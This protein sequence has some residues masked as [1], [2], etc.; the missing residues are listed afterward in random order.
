MRFSRLLILLLCCSLSACDS[1]QSA[2]FKYLAEPSPPEAPEGVEVVRDVGFTETPSGVLK[3]DIY[4][5]VNR[6]EQPLP[7]VV[8]LFG[9]GWEMGNRHQVGGLLGIYHFAQQG[10]AVISIDYRLSSVAIFPAQINDSKAAIRWV[11]LFAEEFQLDAERIGVLGP[12]AGGHLAAL[13]GTSGD[14]AELEGAL[15][16]LASEQLSSRVHAVVDF[17]GP[18]DML[19]A[20][21]HRYSDM[22]DWDAAD[23]PA[24]KLLGG[25]LQERSILATQAN[26]I[27]YVSADDPP[28]LIIH[29]D[30]DP[31]VPLHQSE[32]LLEALQAA[33]VDSELIVVKGGSHGFGGDFY[34]DKLVMRALAFFD[35]H[36]KRP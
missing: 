16:P 15:S 1:V 19:Q 3:L 25:P 24:S 2:V 14:V 11:G 21:A 9:G 7:V 31:I 29:G 30:E 6:G 28:F 18:T 36:L 17:F 27:T 4:R 10:Y 34:T 23:S 35:Q 33:G 32:L 5:P 8:F 22:L 26:P 20:N 12:S 13:L